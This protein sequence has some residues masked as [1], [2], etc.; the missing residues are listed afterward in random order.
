[1]TDHTRTEKIG[2]N[3][4][5]ILEVIQV[6]AR[7]RYDIWY[8][9]YCHISYFALPFVQLS[10]LLTFNVWV[11]RK[12]IYSIVSDKNKFFNRWVT[13]KENPIYLGD[14]SGNLPY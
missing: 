11:I 10:I 3:S 5:L 14:S 4:I 13:K 8:F 1:M 9:F 6:V 12:I 2:G 7:N